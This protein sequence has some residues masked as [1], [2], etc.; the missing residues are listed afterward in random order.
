[1]DSIHNME[2]VRAF[3]WMVHQGE[4][5]IVGY[6]ED[7]ESVVVPDLIFGLPVTRISG[8]P[9]WRKTRLVAITLPKTL[10]SIGEEVFLGC[11]SLASIALPP[12]VQRIGKKAFAGCTTLA[13]VDIPPS[14]ISIEEGA[15]DGCRS[16]ANI[17]I[18]DSVHSISPSA[19]RGCVSLEAIALPA[20]S[21]GLTKADGARFDSLKAALV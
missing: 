18:P 11:T 16:L 21:L 15:F 4:V 12:G 20:G 13:S 10:I 9:F 7:K 5:T 3:N 14:V 19:F 17:H 2:C 6:N 1:M 8:L